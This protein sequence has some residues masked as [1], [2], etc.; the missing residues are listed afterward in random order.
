[1]KLTVAIGE[2]DRYVKS[3]IA[4]LRTAFPELEIEV[5]GNN[6]RDFAGAEVLLART[7]SESELEAAESL[8]AVFVPYTGLNRFP[9]KRMHERGITVVNSH[10]RAKAV[11][12]KALA[13]ALAVMG[14]VVEMHTAMQREGVWLTRKRWGEEYWHSLHGKK[15]GI[16]GMGAIGSHLITLLRPF[17]V[18]V[19]GLKRDLDK[20]LADV[21]VEDIR[22]M[23]EACDVLFVCAPLSDLTRGSIDREILASMHGR[24]LVNIARGE[25][26]EEEAL[27]WALSQGVLAGAGLDVWYQYPEMGSY[28]PTFPSR[29]PIHEL[30]NVVMSPH[31]ASHAVE[32]R[33]GYYREIFEKLHYYLE[34][35]SAMNAVNLGKLVL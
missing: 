29:Y 31:A 2:P 12:E 18:T 35:G 6:E 20:G 9:L 26:I 16:F 28:E 22:A 17:D 23:A 27:Y 8:R 14:R 30:K 15:C 21:Y 3:H 4:E 11:A 25:I 24:F 13:L 19:I 32:F 33:D 10:G 34:H 1:M 7:L 5:L